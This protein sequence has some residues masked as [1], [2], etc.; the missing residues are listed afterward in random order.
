MENR[1]IGFFGPTGSGKTTTINKIAK[2]NCENCKVSYVFQD[3]QLIEKLS[4]LKNV[5]LPLENSYSKTEAELI[6]LNWLKKM[7]LEDKQNVLCEKLSGGEKQRVGL[8]RAFAYDG[9]LFLFDEP[10]AAQDENHKN[11]IMNNI[12]LLK[13]NGKLIYIVSHH[14][15]DL[16]YLCDEIKVFPENSQE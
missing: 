6:A 13:N 5:I 14:K 1:C 10:F 9:T 4:V 7:D 11:L 8:A 2:E 16:E 3:N 15:E 12:K